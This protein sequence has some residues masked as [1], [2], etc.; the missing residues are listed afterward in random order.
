MAPGPSTAGVQTSA[1]RRVQLGFAAR[2][3]DIVGRARIIAGRFLMGVERDRLVRKGF[4]VV[5][6]GSVGV[7]RRIVGNTVFFVRVRRNRLNGWKEFRQDMV[8]LE[9]KYEVG[10]YFKLNALRRIS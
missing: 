6:G 2:S 5:S 8:N 10:S 1:T 9:E 3:G 7:D 4:A